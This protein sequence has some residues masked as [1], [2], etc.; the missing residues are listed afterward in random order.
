MLSI[1]MAFKAAFEFNRPSRLLD[2]ESF[3]HVHLLGAISPWK[4]VM[5][6]FESLY[7]LD[8]V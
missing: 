1:E 5:P 7:S 2:D 8:D 6:G 4:L 3:F